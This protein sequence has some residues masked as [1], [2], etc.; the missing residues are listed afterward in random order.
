MQ[1]LNV[2]LSSSPSGIRGV[3]DHAWR[4]VA[5]AQLR[6]LPVARAGAG[7]APAGHA[8]ARGGCVLAP[9]RLLCPA[10]HPGRAAGREGP[11]RRCQGDLPGHQQ[12]DA[13]SG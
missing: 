8:D 5:R 1:L 4:P 12:A 10:R 7:G 2:A 3:C 11:D 6:H 9:L 13:G